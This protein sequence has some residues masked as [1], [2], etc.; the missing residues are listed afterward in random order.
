VKVPD[1][2]GPDKPTPVMAGGLG[3][4]AASVRLPPSPSIVLTQAAYRWKGH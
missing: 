1:L 3:L 4:A 2:H